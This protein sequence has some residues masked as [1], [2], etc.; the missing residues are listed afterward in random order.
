MVDVAVLGG[1]WAG[2]V[3]ALETKQIFP[4]VEI[5]VLEKSS[6]LG[7]LLKSVS[8]NNHIFDVGGSHVIFSRDKTL[9][10][11]ILSFLGGN[12]IIHQRCAK[13]LLGSIF[14]PYPLE[15]G[16]YVLPPEER[17][18]AL[19]HFLEAWTSRDES[20]VPKTFKDWIYGFFGK[21]VAEKY[22]IPYN[23]KVWK[24]P[25]DEIDVDWVYMPGRLPIPDWR[26]LVKSAIGIPTIGYVEQSIFYY[27]KYGGIQALFNS[28]ANKAEK[29]GVKF[30]KNFAVSRIK[31]S[32]NEW[33]INDKVRAKRLI[34]TIPIKELVNTLDGPEE[35]VK[36]SEG[37]DYNKVAVVGIAL[38]KSAPKQ[39]WIYVPNS[40]ILFHRYAWI[41]NYSPEN[42]PKGESTIL[43]EI[44]LPPDKKVNIEELTNKVVEDFEKLNV[45]KR[46]EMLFANAWMHEYG[47]PIY[48][49][50][51]KEKREIIMAWLKSQ[52]IISVSRW[53]CWQYWNMDRVYQDIINKLEELK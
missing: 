30:V 1:G 20:W 7:G 43:A 36:A 24:R 44:T 9:L 46:D 18:E 49:I 3:F 39:H 38:K 26:D 28:V 27:P 40:D 47:Y 31:R 19:I 37:L 16:L 42:S 35:V 48:K 6:I 23:E 52:N 8:I 34:N 11:R 10:E 51:H 5:V 50:G 22:L 2:V 29:L 12:F 33:V 25:L 53:G 32:S 13:V 14:V 4:N 45:F 41:S 21:W 17:A 15:N